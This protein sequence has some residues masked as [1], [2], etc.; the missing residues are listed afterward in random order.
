L[1]IPAVFIDRDGVIIEEK[2]YITDYSQVKLIENSDKAINMLN[3]NGFLAI[4]ITNQSSIGRGFITEKKLEEIHE[5]IISLLEAKDAKLD[6]IYYCPHL[7]EQD[8]NKACDC[9]KPKTGLINKAVL[10]HDIDLKN[11]YII[12]DRISDI[13]TGI[14][15]GIKTI[16]VKSGYNE[17]DINKK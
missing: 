7:P 17:Y 5:H 4:C 15:A 13:K 6:S 9:R 2:S 12:G 16:Y 10:E 11:S 1:D 8:A 3:Q 14:N